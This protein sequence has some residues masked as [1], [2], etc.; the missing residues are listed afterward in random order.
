MVVKLTADVTDL[1]ARVGQNEASID[2]HDHSITNLHSD[3]SSLVD[4][5]LSLRQE[6][7]KL[8]L[9]LFGLPEPADE[10]I[11]DLLLAFTEAIK[12]L[13]VDTIP[14]DT[15][16]RIGK[17]NGTPRPI[18]IRFITLKDRDCV[19]KRRSSLP[20]GIIIKEDIPFETRR[21]H[22]ILLKKK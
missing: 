10:S 13:S 9:I 6:L 18:K 14:V 11:E 16:F 19:Y 21:A 22:A 1:K 4:A 15:V 12:A 5:N 7:N 17:P 20:D 2:S 3:V 8:N